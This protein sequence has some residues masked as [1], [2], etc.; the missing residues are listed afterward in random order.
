MAVLASGGK[1]FP[2][3]TITPSSGFMGVPYC[4]LLMGKCVSLFPCHNLFT[5]TLFMYLTWNLYNNFRPFGS[6]SK[7]FRWE[8]LIKQGEEETSPHAITFNKKKGLR[9]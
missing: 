4:G 3:Y 5:H 7:P 6:M 1:F 8:S 2:H 9:Q